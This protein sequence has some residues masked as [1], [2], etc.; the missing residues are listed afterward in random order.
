MCVFIMSLFST[1]YTIPTK[2]KCTKIFSVG[3]ASFNSLMP[4]L[5][6]KIL[7][8]LTHN[9]LISEWG[10]TL[11]W[12]NCLTRC[13]KGGPFDWHCTNWNIF[14]C[15]VRVESNTP[16]FGWLNQ[17]VLPLVFLEFTFQR[18]SVLVMIEVF[19][20]RSRP[21]LSQIWSRWDISGSGTICLTHNSLV[22]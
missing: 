6:F 9:S 11:K 16:W 21:E 20:T 2:E 18:H 14:T 10:K 8:C 12:G 22:S 17:R 4:H 1:I 13:S 15:L 3:I 19:L 7:A 5:F